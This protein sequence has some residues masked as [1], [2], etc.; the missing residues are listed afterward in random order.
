MRNSLVAFLA[1]LP[2]VPLT[3]AAAE[4]PAERR[5]TIFYTGAIQGAVEPCGCTS[6]PL[7]DIARL[8][9]LVR[10]AVQAAKP[11]K[12]AGVLVVDAGNLGYPPGALSPKRR[13]GAQLR[14]AF[15]ARELG[16][17][18]FGGSA[19]G[20]YDLSAGPEGVTPRRLAANVSAAPVLEPSKVRD[21]GGIRVGLLG[22]A[23]PALARSFGW[24]AEDPAAAATREA[25]KL[26]AAG[27]EVV[28]ALAALDANRARQVARSGAVDF[29][30]LGKDVGDD[31]LARPNV[32]GNT[33]I[34]APAQDLQRVGR[35]DIVLR[36]RPA[37]GARVALVDA[38]GVEAQA[39]ARA[40][41]ERSLARLDSD[42]QRWDKEGGADPAFVAARRQERDQVKAQL[43]SA[44]AQA[45]QPPA[46]GS[47]FVSD[48]IPL[49]RALPRDPQIATAMHALDKAVGQANLRVAEPPPPAPPERASFTG[50]RSCAGCHKKETA[51]WKTTVHA[52]A[53]KTLVDGGKTGL[54]DCVSCHV[55]GYGEIGGSSLGHVER[56]T[57]VQ[58]ETCHG[59]GS[60][61]VK[62]EGLEEPPAVHT[63]VPESTCTRCHNEKHSD[64]FNYTAY[65]RDILGPGHGQ[66][67]REKLGDGPTGGQLRRAAMAKAKA[68]GAAQVKG[69]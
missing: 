27:A 17:L 36:G 9:G 25:Q 8:T 58:C 11:A 7:G 56:L 37:S 64:T 43:A 42:L 67:A 68:A 57:A 6:D 52:H 61:H 51:F 20:E 44:P 50:D 12:A 60:L 18:P 26:R 65:L 53:W 10:R 47:Y 62:A 55:T 5:A 16:R 46:T 49:R 1:L 31:G 24:T 15:L 63:R 54:D 28:I 34:L 22:L 45:W 35:L 59:P 23:D 13:E 19:L 2:T 69:L 38:G 41:L 66:D 30:V 48:L 29:I 32:V 4:P 40:A 3:A 14:A 33:F 21:V 39:Q